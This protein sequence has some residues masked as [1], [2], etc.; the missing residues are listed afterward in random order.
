MKNFCYQGSEHD[1]GYA[2]LK[3]LLAIISKNKNYL[4]LPKE[5]ECDT[6]SLLDLIEIA[7]TH[8]VNLGGYEMEFNKIHDQKLPLII[9]VRKNHLVVLTKVKN[10]IYYINDPSEGKLR[11]KGEELANLYSGHVLRVENENLN[12]EYKTEKPRLV[13][14]TYTYVHIAVGA[15]VV[16]M[17]GLDFYLM[18][19]SENI[20]FIFM[21]IMFLILVE[22]FENWYLVKMSDYFDSTYIPLY[23]RKQQHQNSEEYQ[24]YLGVKVGLFNNSKS[25]VVY[26]SLAIILGVLISINDPRNL[27]VIAIIMLYKAV[28]K[29][30]TQFKDQERIRELSEGEAGAFDHQKEAVSTLLDLNK[31]ANKHALSLT[32]RNCFFQLVLMFLTL[33]MMI[34]SKTMSANYA[35]FHFGIYF[36]IG[37]GVTLIFDRITNHQDRVKSVTQFC[38]RCGL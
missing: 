33:F 38:D 32:T 36:V 11:M 22:V 18:N 1:C 31:K 12:R 30:L 20:P 15:L 17:L 35:V 9:E 10:G 3:M 25:L 26:A 2:S 16:L 34:L 8:Q 24:R 23:F 7:A 4:Y 29:Y 21:L 14:K 6:Y 37:Q 28:E 13:P 27:L 5:N 19:L